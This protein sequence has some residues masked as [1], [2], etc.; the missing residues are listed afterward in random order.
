MGCV[1][2]VTSAEKYIHVYFPKVALAEEFLSLE[3]D[4][5][6]DLIRHDE[7]NVPSEETIFEACMRW[8]KF[9]EELRSP[10][11]PKVLANVRLPLLSPQY[12]ADRVARE[13]MIRSS[14]QCRDLL[15]E[16]KDFH[17]MPERRGLLQSFRYKF[18]F[19]NHI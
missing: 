19:I 13:E 14:L 18:I 4:E 9:K 7:L 15:D 3:F 6:L 8:V 5:L 11:F 2:L 12:L 16:A 1:N 17:L 10:L